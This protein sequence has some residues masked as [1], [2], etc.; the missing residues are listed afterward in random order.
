[1][2]KPP[3]TVYLVRHGESE[4]NAGGISQP[5][6]EIVLSEQ[7]HRQS[8]IIAE[9]LYQSLGKKIAAVYTSNYIRTLQTAQ[10]LLEQSNLSAQTLNDLHEFN[11]LD[12]TDIAN[13]NGKARQPI[14]ERYWQHATPQTQLSADTESFIQF[15]QRVDN[16][17]LFIKEQIKIGTYDKQKTAVFYTHGIW[18]G[19]L[20]WRLLGNGVEQIAQMRRF[21]QFEQ[22]LAINNCAV[23]T[24]I[25]MGED[26]ALKR[27]R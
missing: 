13:L 4:S 10:P 16:T 11:Y 18:L 25:L 1:M 5:N 2:N 3:C 7:G 15:T 27:I 22:S 24:L 23:Y 26:G 6:P 17:L 14:R 21:R 19:M 12:F 9:Y 8:K 20:A